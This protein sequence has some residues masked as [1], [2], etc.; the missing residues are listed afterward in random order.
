MTHTGKLHNME[1][2][3]NYRCFLSWMYFWW[4]TTSIYLK[5]RH[6]WLLFFIFVSRAT[7]QT[8]QCP[9]HQSPAPPAADDHCH[10]PRPALVLTSHTPHSYVAHKPPSVKTRM[11]RPV[12]KPWGEASLPGTS[13]RGGKVRGGVR[14]AVTSPHLD[15]IPLS[16]S[17]PHKR[18]TTVQTPLVPLRRWPSRRLWPAAWDVL[19]L[20]A[21]PAHACELAG[22]SPTDTFGSALR[23][24]PQ[25]QA[26]ILSV[27]QRR[28][29]G[30]RERRH[31][32]GERRGVPER[33]TCA[34]RRWLL[35]H[36]CFEPSGCLIKK[37]T[38]NN[39]EQY[40]LKL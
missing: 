34:E 18:M 4:Q 29:T 16:H 24:R 36:L 14:P 35:L 33:T 6:K 8:V 31:S 26:V 12:Q 40:F 32:A 13:K 10:K 1:K 38:Q 5:H 9:P 17:W 11:N 2:V 30:A 22:R 37:W 39:Q 21:R 28:T 23:R 15:A 25:L 20:S 19:I 3:S 7:A 27:T